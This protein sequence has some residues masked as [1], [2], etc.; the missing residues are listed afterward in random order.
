MY[1][2]HLLRRGCTLLYVGGAFA[3]GVARF[4]ASYILRDTFMKKHSICKM[5]SQQNTVDSCRFY[6]K[7]PREPSCMMKDVRK[8]LS[9]GHELLLTCKRS[10]RPLKMCVLVGDFPKI[11]PWLRQPPWSSLCWWPRS[12]LSQSKGGENVIG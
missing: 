2:T 12:S 10:K 7:W 3:K 11:E 1:M 6:A 9:Q 5:P 8:L 4:C